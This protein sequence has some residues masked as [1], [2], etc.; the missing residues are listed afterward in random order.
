MARIWTPDD[1]Q[2][3][4]GKTL[5]TEPYSRKLIRPALR[6]LR[7]HLDMD[8]AY[9][10]EI[11]DDQSVFQEVDAP[12]LEHLIKPGDARPLDQVYC[13]HIIDGDIPELMPDTAADPI[14]C[15]MP[16]TS[17]VPIG[18]HLSVPIRLSD[19]RIYGMFCCFGFEP[20]T[21]LGVRDLAMLRAFAELIADVIEQELVANRARQENGERIRGVIDKRQFAPVFQPIWNL[22]KGGMESVE[23]LTRFSAPPMRAPDL[24]FQDAAEANLDGELELATIAEAL[25]HLGKLPSGTCMN[26]NVSPQTAST[27]AFVETFSSMD[28]SRVILELTEH[29]SVES[30]DALSESLA[31]LRNRGM[32]LAIDDAGSGYACLRHILELKP[33]IVK[34]DA[35]LIRDVDRDVARQTL[36]MALISFCEGISVRLLAEG[37]ETEAELKALCQLGVRDFQGY[38]LGR[39]V[40]IADLEASI[41]VAEIASAYCRKYR[42][43]PSTDL[44]AVAPASGAA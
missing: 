33:D 25:K 9:V 38:L 30:Y 14:A 22:E 2:L 17:A 13:K 43:A 7:A 29:A 10:S 32:R 5:R 27:P 18:R 41:D 31:A 42:I 44:F 26:I 35:D 24:W 11:V 28:I 34:M 36:V 15:Q 20:D 23:A 8:V 16:V 1:L 6:I 39:P 40:P 4:Q 21:A 37:V 12:G 3:F 19:G